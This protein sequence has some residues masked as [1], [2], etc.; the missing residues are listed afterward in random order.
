MEKVVGKMVLP[1]LALGVGAALAAG[2]FTIGSIFSN[3]ETNVYEP[4]GDVY[5]EPSQNAGLQ[6]DTKTILIAAAVAYLVM[7]K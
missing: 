1:L 5:A 6:I 2:G 7:K 3:P 4:S